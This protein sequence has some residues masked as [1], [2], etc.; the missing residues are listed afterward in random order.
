MRIYCHDL[1]PQII[2]EK[3]HEN[4]ADPILSVSYTTIALKYFLRITKAFSLIC[5][6]KQVQNVLNLKINSFLK[7]IC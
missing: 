6:S 4:L 7:V 5:L 3:F 1:R 2:D